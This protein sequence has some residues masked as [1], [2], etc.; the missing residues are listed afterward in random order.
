MRAIGGWMLDTICRQIA[1]WQAAGLPTVSVALNLS[2]A[3]FRAPAG[4]VG[5]IMD[6]LARHGVAPGVLEL[7]ID[8]AT[9]VEL[10]RE[11]EGDLTQLARL[12]PRLVFDGFGMG[13]FALTQIGEY[14]FARLKIARRQVADAAVGRAGA[15]IL[16]TVIGLAGELGIEVAASGVETAA[17]LAVVTASGCPVAQGYHI[18]PPV[19]AAE[20]E[21]LLRAGRIE[22]GEMAIISHG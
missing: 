7:E 18:C 6:T 16:R 14:G 3:Q 12:G 17:E 4:F 20:V 2:A 10:V 9:M 8:E 1:A 21:Q 11:H 15:A 13:Q 22:P 5:E 19:P